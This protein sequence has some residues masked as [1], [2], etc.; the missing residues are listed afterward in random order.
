[1]L[2][3]D[4]AAGPKDTTVNLFFIPSSP[5]V[6]CV[7]FGFK[8]FIRLLIQDLLI[9]EWH[10]I[11]RILKGVIFCLRKCCRKRILQH[12][13]RSCKYKR[14]EK[15]DKEITIIDQKH[16]PTNNEICLVKHVSTI[17]TFRLKFVIIIVSYNICTISRMKIRL[18]TLYTRY[19]FTATLS[20]E[21]RFRPAEGVAK[22][23]LKCKQSHHQPSNWRLAWF[24]FLSNK[25]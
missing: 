25:L 24:V 6:H 16:V 5:F 21:M 15:V 3:T 2:S 8:Y 18:I 10:E 17:R 12:C 4:N 1:M 23:N 20:D 7:Y 19:F 11:G 13:L 14:C 22:E 9:K